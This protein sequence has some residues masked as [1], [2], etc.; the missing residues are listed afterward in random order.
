[1]RI[2]SPW[3]TRL[4]VRL[5]VVLFRAL[6]RTCRV[7]AWC[8]EPGTAPCQVL[9]DRRLVYC[10]WHDLLLNAIFSAEQPATCGLVSRHQDGSYL[11]DAMQLCNVRPV[12]GSSSK[13]GAAA[14]R[15]LVDATRDYHVAITPDGP[16]GP[17]HELKPGIV[18]VA[19]Q[20][21]RQV[22][23]T[24]SAC[25]RGWRIQ[26]SWTD[27]L[28]PLPFT[29]I[30]YRVGRPLD[31]PPDLTREEITEHT[32]RLQAEMQRVETEVEQL[33]RGV[34][35][36]QVLGA[37]NQTPTTDTGWFGGPVPAEVVPHAVPI[38]PTPTPKSTLTPSESASPIRRAA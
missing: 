17:R 28:I 31:V 3:L 27:M 7:K 21:G 30:Y 24:A 35:P 29:T 11:A 13:G 16:R 1:M 25:R 20:T 12:R 37:D 26:G 6:Y 8:D 2:R 10:I 33:A 19:S 5:V 38:H 23:A 36:A 14:L 15:E 4:G 32:A 22:A 34:D 9:G 18:F